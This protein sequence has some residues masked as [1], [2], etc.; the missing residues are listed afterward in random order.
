ML[1]IQLQIEACE[2][3][4]YIRTKSYLYMNS[5]ARTAIIGIGQWPAGWPEHKPMLV[6]NY[7]YLHIHPATVFVL[8]LL[9]F[10]GLR[11]TFYVLEI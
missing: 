11:V 4:A 8:I 2:R 3:T 6:A 9:R 7:R 1:K 5:Y 10:P